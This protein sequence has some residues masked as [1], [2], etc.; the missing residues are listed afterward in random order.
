MGTDGCCC[1]ASVVVGYS[2]SVVGPDVLGVC[3]WL[4]PV[5]SLVRIAVLPCW[6]S[7]TS[8]RC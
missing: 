4:G 6:L 3:L 7:R 5:G 8:M 2:N 1:G